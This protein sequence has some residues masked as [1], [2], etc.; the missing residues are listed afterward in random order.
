[1]K[2]GGIIKFDVEGCVYLLNSFFKKRLSLTWTAMDTSK[3]KEGKMRKVFNTYIFVVLAV[4]LVISLTFVARGSSDQTTG[5]SK[6][7]SEYTPP[8]N[9]P[10]GESK[11]MQLVGYSDLN[12]RGGGFKM[13]LQVIGNKW[14]LW[15]SH[16][17]HRGWS[18]LDVTDVRNPQYVNYIEG[19]A[20]TGCFQVQ[21][22]DDINGNPIALLG[23]AAAGNTWGGD[24]TKPNAEGLD[25]YDARDPYNPRFLSHWGTGT[26]KGLHKSFYAGGRYAYMVAA[27]P[28]YRGNILRILDIANPSNPV[29]VGK[30]AMP[31]QA[32]EVPPSAGSGGLH[33]YPFVRGNRAYCSWKSGAIILDISDVTTPKLVS[34]LPFEPTFSGGCHT[35]WPLMDSINGRKYAWANGEATNENPCFGAVCYS[36]LIDITDETK[37]FLVSVMPVPKVPSTAPFDAYCEKGGRFGP[38]DIHTPTAEFHYQEQREDR[39]YNAYFSGGLRVFDIRNPFHPKEIAYY[40]PPDPTVRYGSLPG[41]DLITSS[42]IVIADSRG[43]IYFSDKNWG[44][45][46]VRCTVP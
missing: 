2:K 27:H 26:T 16:L 31:D 35:F 1:V 12:G 8:T 28:D 20:N 38:H 18:I 15:V 14:Y 7:H 17:W 33:G 6:E 9:V 30:W 34:R 29:E 10:L 22:A 5:V 3:K 41:P 45:H 11:N 36:A 46:I 19:P 32:N 40:V 24:S 4:S 42:E 13:S 44:I 21:V 39:I 43:N 25:I 37:P 23:M